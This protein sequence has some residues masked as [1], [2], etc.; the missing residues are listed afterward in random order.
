[1]IYRRIARMEE[2]NDELADRDTDCESVGP[3]AKNRALIF[4]QH[5]NVQCR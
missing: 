2:L 5:A 4:V 1:M 3:S